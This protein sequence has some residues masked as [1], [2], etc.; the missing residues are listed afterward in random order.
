MTGQ[1]QFLEIP[2]NHFVDNDLAENWREYLLD[3]PKK[4]LPFDKSSNNGLFPVV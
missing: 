3:D 4:V 2:R 1:D